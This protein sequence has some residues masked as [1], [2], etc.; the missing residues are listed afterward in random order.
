LTPAQEPQR[1]TLERA[2]ALALEHNPQLRVV[3]AQREGAEAG[4]VTARAYPNPEM[5]AMVGPQFSRPNALTGPGA[6]GLLQHY[7]IHQP[8][9]LPAVRAARLRTAQA[10]R[11]GSLHALQ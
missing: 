10:G 6:R 11:E 3:A 7:S 1:L 8:I 5:T 9:E 2:L 4:V